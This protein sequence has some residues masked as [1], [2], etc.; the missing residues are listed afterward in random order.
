MYYLHDKDAGT[1]ERVAWTQT[2]NIPTNDPDKAFKWMA[3]TAMHADRLKQEAGVAPTGR[4]RKSG[5]VY[6]Y[7]LA[8][9]PDQNPDQEVMLEAAYETL[10]LLKLEEHEAV[11]VAH[12]DTAHPHV[13][14]IVNLIHPGHGKKA[15]VSYDRLTMSQWA[16][17]TERNEGEIRCEQRVINN[18]QR[19]AL[20]KEDRQLALI[21]HKE[22][23]LQMAAQVRELYECSD[24]GTAFSAALK[25]SGYTLA[26]GNRRAFV[27]VDKD[28]AI[29]SLSRQ[30]KGQRA[31]DIR[32]RLAGIEGLPD[33]K[34][35]S[36]DRKHFDRDQYETERQ[37]K[38][39]DA[40]IAAS[41]NDTG[42]SETK[43]QEPTTKK[44]QR[45]EPNPDTEHLRKLD[46]L[47][48]WEEHS[49][50]LKTALEQRQ[51]EQYGRSKLEEQI[52][53]LQAE[54]NDGNS[55]WSRWTGKQK[56]RQEELDVLQQN[57]ANIDQ[58]I[59]EQ[60]KA[61]E[62]KLQKDKP[63]YAEELKRKEAEYDQRIR[64]HQA[65]RDSLDK[66]PEIER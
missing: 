39:V 7:S 21:K 8:W 47:R 35:L 62:L 2:H 17:K 42:Q 3:Y 27:L 32:E 56:K 52:R 45:P 58:R 41:E 51:Q 54:L 1:K 14:C 10:Q 28:G 4:K 49:S 20:A 48:A 65:Q 33:A 9:H 13:H 61:L 18:E 55:A 26:Q 31:K 59:A 44:Q 16:E 66:G 34:E 64:A 60:H 37:K 12:N 25:E 46:A 22:Q 11:F 57:L 24:N 5:P 63:G 23:K 43:K 36:Y 29:Y 50:R 19:R 38:I 6:S 15:V 53:K 40:A 30:L